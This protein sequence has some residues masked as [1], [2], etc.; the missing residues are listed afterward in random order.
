MPTPTWITINPMSGQL[1]MDLT[2]NV[3]ENTGREPRVAVIT[4]TNDSQCRP[5]SDFRIYQEGVSVLFA[6]ESRNQL[7]VSQQGEDFVVRMFSNT[8]TLGV[9]VPEFVSINNVQIQED[10]LN[11]GESRTIT[12]V[13]TSNGL[14]VLDVPTPYGRSRMYNLSIS[15]AVQKNLTGKDREIV[16]KVES[17]HSTDET[18][19]LEFILTQLG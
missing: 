7:T 5:S 9:S 17:W 6:Q 12:L 11:S 4:G 16:V 18:K 13:G 10:A 15:C 1:S 2:V 3:Q 19:K 14:H 8:H